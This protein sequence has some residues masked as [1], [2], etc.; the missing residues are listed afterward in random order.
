MKSIR[1]KLQTA[2]P[3][4]QFRAF[5][6]VYGIGRH[7]RVR[8]W[9]LGILIALIGALF[10]P[11][12]QN[13]RA[14]GT[15]TTL[16][17]EERAQEVNSIIAG[18]IVKWHVKEGD[19]VQAG[20]TL[21][22]LAEVKDAYLDPK[23]LERTQEQITAKGTS[24]A[25][26]N[27][28]MAATSMQIQAIEAARSLKLGQLENKVRQLQLKIVSDSMEMLAAFND[29][30][31]AEAQYSRQ[32]IMRD[33][34]L[35][36]LAQVEQRL[37]S[38]QSALA[39]KTSA[40]I[41]F[42]NTK[43]DLVNARME[44]Q[45]T[46]QEYAE[47]SFKARGER[48]AAQSEMATGQAELSKLSNQYANYAIR[49]GQYYLIAPQSGQVVGAAKSGIN[50]IVKEGEK[51]L[52]IIPQ[53]VQH[54]VKLFIRPVDLPLL[55]KGQHVRFQFDGYPAIIFSGWPAASYGMF[56]GVVTAIERTVSANGKFR[57]L[58]GEETG[59]RPWPTT[60]SLGTGAQ[61]IALLKDVPIGYELWRNINGFPPDYYVPTK[62]KDGKD[63]K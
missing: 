41:K 59:R 14:R 22:V 44:Q 20:D 63:K 25:S 12:T 38:Y 40:E 8:Y 27:E 56:D 42:S 17:Q 48:A 26:Y 46:A 47:K 52:E 19:I 6:S 62:A 58:V 43:T 39:K 2:H 23:L 10:L 4:L 55:R 54:A 36:S 50:E 30:R 3:D 18:R 21:A 7:S 51:L 35:A 60:L 33:S 57:V 31:I 34:G 61:G 45:G 1:E 16:R 5:E 9:V 53:D 28:K 24:V 29:F 15:V 11:W 13:I 37:Q 49:A 32:R